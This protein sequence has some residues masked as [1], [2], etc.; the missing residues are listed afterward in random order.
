MNLWTHA[1]SIFLQNQIHISNL[2]ELIIIP[3]HQLIPT[4]T[5]CA[6][7]V[8]VGLLLVC[9][10]PRLYAALHLEWK[11]RTGGIQ[12]T[13]HLASWRYC[14]ISWRLY[15]IPYNT[16]GLKFGPWVLFKKQF[17]NDMFPVSWSLMDNQFWTFSLTLLQIL[18]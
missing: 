9:F 16:K 4:F 11:T 17:N 6:K 1:G 15:L 18:P 7:I 13:W 14:G 3:S 8:S 2:A 10:N 5:C 12:L